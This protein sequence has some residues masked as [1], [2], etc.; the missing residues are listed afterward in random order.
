MSA[1][2]SA[3]VAVSLVALAACGRMFGGDFQID[4][5]D[6]GRRAEFEKM[7]A[8]NGVVF[9][10]NDRGYIVCEGG[11]VKRCRELHQVWS[12]AMAKG[13]STGTP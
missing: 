10:H 2:S 1:R 4:I 13:A 7:L 6:P 8:S 5:A 9:R 3:L 12:D 11:Q